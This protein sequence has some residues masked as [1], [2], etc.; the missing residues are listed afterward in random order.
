MLVI[1]VSHTTQSQQLSVQETGCLPFARKEAR[2]NSPK[3]Q[4]GGFGLANWGLF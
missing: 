1:T 4:Y 3:N 2:E